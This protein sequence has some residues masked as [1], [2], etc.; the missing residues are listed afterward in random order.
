MFT[1]LLESRATTPRRAGGTLFSACAH[2]ALIAAAVAVTLPTRGDATPRTDAPARNVI[3][4]PVAPSVPGRVAPV[5]PK[6]TTPRPPDLTA[7]SLPTITAPTITPTTLPPIDFAA[8][9]LPPEQ[10]V[11]GTGA[12]RRPI[13][14]GAPTGG[15]GAPDGVVDYSGADVI[16]RVL[17]NSPT[18]RY[19]DALRATGMT[20]RVMI[21]F[22]VDTSGQAEADGIRVLDATHPMFA[23]VVRQALPRFRFSAGE[24]NGRKVRTMVQ[25]P[26][27][28]SLR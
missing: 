22:V 11:I 20:G 27:T 23:D 17:G 28:F 16:P 25:L 5:A 8:P 9:V 10:L 3:Y 15:V 18:L 14:G 2:G 6:T 4:V 24:A 13:D 21:Q 7:P 1:T 19:P 26:F 12:S